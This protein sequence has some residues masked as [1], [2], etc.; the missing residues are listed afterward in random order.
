MRATPSLA[1]AARRPCEDLRVVPADFHEFFAASAGVAGALIGLLFVAISVVGERL[2]RVEAGTQVHRIRAYA[3]LI[4]FNNALA[5]SLFALIP[6][7]LIGGAGIT[8]SLIGLAFVIASLL[9]L[10]RVRP[11]RLTTA[12]DATFIAGLAVVFVL[13]LIAGLDVNAHP[14]D[15]GSVET[16]AILVIVCFLLGI[17]RAWELIGGPSL[18]IP[19]EVMALVRG[20]ALVAAGAKTAR[21]RETTGEAAGQAEAAGAKDAP[22]A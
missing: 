14:G 8:V 4:A 16:I 3:A 2:A 10:L 18:G 11:L 20:D 13:Q 22:P 6:G 5:I 12:R 15:S 17:A 7:E 1:T 19:Q 9:S 21:E